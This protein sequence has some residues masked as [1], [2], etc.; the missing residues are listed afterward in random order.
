M[1]GQDKA[2]WKSHPEDEGYE[3]GQLEFCQNLCW[4]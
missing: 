2:P 1:A 4:N 3:A